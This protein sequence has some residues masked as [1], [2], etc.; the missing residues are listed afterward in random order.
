MKL[1][2]Y[3]Q[4]GHGYGLDRLKRACAVYEALKE[5]DPIL[6][7]TDFRAGTFAKEVF[8]VRKTVSVDLI[9]NLP[10]IME[11]GDA[12]IFDSDEPSDTMKLNM[13]AYCSELFEVGN[14]IPNTLV[15]S[16]FRPSSVMQDSLFF[17]GD[18]D[19]NEEFLSLL[20]AYPSTVNLNVLL[21]HYYFL[22]NESKI[23]SKFNKTYEDSE[24]VDAISVHK[25]ILTGSVQ[26]A[27]ESLACGN[28]P[29]IFTRN[30][31]FNISIEILSVVN[32]YNIPVITNASNLVDILSQFDEIRKN[33]PNVIDVEKYDFS[34]VIQRLQSVQQK[35]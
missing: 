35:I 18:D 30:D 32:Q 8:G 2:I 19:Y 9:E 3:A 7:T 34:Y 25:Y 24:Y 20:D 27:I 5:F 15:H 16:C 10:N 14:T 21:G 6:C 29:I 23:S 22:G 11:R 28:Y 1:Y 13:K 12:L 31:K 33:Y 17:F 4:S 26:A